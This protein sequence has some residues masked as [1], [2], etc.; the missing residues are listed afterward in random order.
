LG[1]SFVTV[2]VTITSLLRTEAGAGR[3]A[4]EAF[5]K[6]WYADDRAVGRLDQ[7]LLEAAKRQIIVSA[8]IL[9]PQAKADAGYGKMVAHPERR[10]LRGLT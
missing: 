9:V 1:V 7:A 4:F 5:G 8:I 6:T 3:T 2:N 10:T